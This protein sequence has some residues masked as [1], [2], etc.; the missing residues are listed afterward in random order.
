MG[1]FGGTATPEELGLTS[2]SKYYFENPLYDIQTANSL[3]NKKIKAQTNKTFGQ[4]YNS[5]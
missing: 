5:P 4:N 2:M 3:R 1:P